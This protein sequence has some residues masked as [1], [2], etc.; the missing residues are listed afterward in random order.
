MGLVYSDKAVEFVVMLVVDILSWPG[1]CAVLLTG[2]L[3][4]R[5][6]TIL[7]CPN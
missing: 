6:P 4:R 7:L 1:S 2:L 5:P 3:A